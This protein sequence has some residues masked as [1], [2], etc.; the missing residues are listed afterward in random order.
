MA[1][2]EFNSNLK[3]PIIEKI[4]GFIRFD[5]SRDVLH[6][7]ILNHK[8]LH[9]E[10]SKK[11]LENDELGLIIVGKNFFSSIDNQ[12]LLISK[13]KSIFGEVKCKY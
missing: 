8:Q 5:D 4:N 2:D 11:K 12:N 6:E 3:F 10:E 1:I 7:V 9:I 13:L